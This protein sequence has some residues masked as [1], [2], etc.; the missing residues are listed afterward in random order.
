MSD[1][2]SLLA[3]ALAGR[4]S[5]DRQVGTG[6]MATVYLAHDLR[7]DRKVAVKVLRSELAAV[8]GAERF[9][10]EIKT[11]AR[12][13]HPNILP[14]FDS[15]RARVPPQESTK[16]KEAGE[17][18]LYYVMPFI[19]GETLREK[20]NRDT[21]LSVDEAVRITSEVADALDYAHRQGV[22]HRDIKPENILLSEGRPML[23]DFGI[24]LAVQAAGGDRLT[25][26]GLTLGTPHYMSPEQATAE[27]EL[28]LRSDIYSL[29]VILY[30]MLA[31]VLPHTGA[32]AQA[33]ILGI[34]ADEVQPLRELR[35]SVPPHVAAATAKALEKVPA[36]RFESAAA[37]AAAL[38]DARAMSAEAIAAYVDPTPPS[39]RLRSRRVPSG[40]V[41]V[42]MALSAAAGWLLRPTP[43]PPR[44]SVTRFTV[45]VPQG[46]AMD[47]RPNLALSP[48]GRTL[49][50][51]V[52][53]TLFKRS[54]GKDSAEALGAAPGKCCPRFTEDGQWIYF[55]REVLGDP[56]GISVNGGPVVK[57][58]A[59]L[60]GQDL[61][62]SPEAQA[63][64][65]L[66]RAGSPDWEQVT[67]LD[68][69]GTEGAHWWPQL[70]PD[71][72]HLLYSALRPSMMWNGAKVVAQEIGT[73]LRTVIAEDATFGRYIPTGH[74]VYVD[75]EGTLQG[76]PFDLNH[77]RV[78]GPPKVIESGV[79]TAYWGGAASIA[80]AEAGT[81]AFV[82]GSGWENH[83]LTWV[84]REGI[85]L[86]HVG[87]PATMEGVHLSPDGRYAL[88]YVAS[89]TSDISRFDV[90]SG[91]E[92]R[93]TFGEQTDD[94]P[95][96]SPDGRRIAY[97][98][99]VSGQDHRIYTMDAPGQG[100]HE[101]LYSAHAYTAPRSWSVDGSALGLYQDGSF[102]VLNLEDQ[103]LD[104]VTTRAAV[105]GGRFSPDG[106]W[107]AY[108]SSDTGQNEI[109]VVSFPDLSGKQQVS[110]GGGRLPEWSRESGELFYVKADTVMVSDVVT[111][112]SF[113]YSTP[114]PLFVSEDF[115]EIL[116]GYAVSA[117]G[118]RFLYPAPNPDAPAREI[119]VVLNW[120][121]ELRSSLGTQEQD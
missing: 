88:T 11:L 110:S 66:R 24:A 119:H 54:L 105:E 81:L 76:V 51:F 9:V 115:T 98:Q 29:A 89:A 3:A 15:G 57:M 36:D 44:P 74:V 101:L 53:D 46:H 58:T 107:L 28:S 42:L 117:N 62:Y 96:W 5:I 1:S 72:Q 94:N 50:Y 80:I 114:R 22:I 59:Q 85:V 12:L 90:V 79:R 100:P 83:Q 35:R 65:F 32:T 60:R 18:F 97:H 40:W 17:A 77:L 109:Y 69:L 21:Q 82:R 75:A 37:F 23:S 6:G 52:G 71:G 45:P 73:D 34:L 61:V 95:V 43:E 67:T 14:L 64:V 108:V 33:I 38:T 16:E 39:S 55:S 121:E 48:D 4:Y 20:L 30:E 106:R 26:T 56:E 70:L 87:G 68:S 103:S 27:K 41:P 91:E 99:V 84:D 93:L 7:H 78:T 63:G 25:G 86:G 49:A 13:Q 112:G 111:G 116:V 8:V 19:A 10:Q 92:R 2:T 120:F 47:Y 31:G 113:T 118:Q 104:T 102:L